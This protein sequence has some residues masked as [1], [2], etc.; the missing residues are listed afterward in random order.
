MSLLILE[1]LIT[2][3]VDVELLIKLFGSIVLIPTIPDE[4]SPP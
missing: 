2:A 1:E 4:K 3:S